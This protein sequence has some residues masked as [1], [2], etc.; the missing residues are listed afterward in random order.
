MRSRSKPMGDTNY[1]E[2]K[3]TSG[4]EQIIGAGERVNAGRH[5]GLWNYC[6]VW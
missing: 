6:S 4:L 2:E 1:R 5:G 3:C